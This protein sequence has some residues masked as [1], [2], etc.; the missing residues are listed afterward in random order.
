MRV[1]LQENTLIGEVKEA[2]SGG[3]I[4]KKRFVA[5]YVTWIA[6]LI[7][8][9]LGVILAV[10]SETKTVLDRCITIGF[11][12]IVAIV[13]LYATKKYLR[14]QSMVNDIQEV[15][16]R[17]N[18]DYVNG[19]NQLLWDRYKNKSQLFQS[20]ELNRIYRS[21]LEENYRLAESGETGT[22]ANIEDYFNYKLI[23]SLVKK[24]VMNLIAGAMTG[25]GILG[26]FIGLSVGLQHFSTGSTEEISNSIAPLMDG[27]KVA[28]HTSIYGMILS[29]LFNAAYKNDIEHAYDIMDDFL[30]SFKAK[31]AN[32][33]ETGMAKMMV[34]YQKKQSEEMSELVT[35]MAAQMSEILVPQFDRLNETLYNFADV[36]SKAQ[37]DGI[38]SIVESFVEQMNQSLGDRFKELAKV[39]DETCDWQR[40][41][42]A[43]MERVLNHVGAMTT[44]IER[45]N[46]LSEATIQRTSE[47]I[48]KVDSLQ[49]MIN[50]KMEA[51]DQRLAEYQTVGERQAD[52]IEALVNYEKSITEASKTFSADMVKQ[53]QILEDIESTI[54][55]NTVKN[56]ELLTS[57][58]EECSQAIAEAA[59]RQVESIVDI[60]NSASE[61]LNKA[62]EELGMVS[63]Q[64]GTELNASLKDAIDTVAHAS[65][66]CSTRITDAARDQIKSITD[67]T[68]S[69]SADMNTAA[70]GLNRAMAQMNDKMEQRIAK[71]FELFDNE[72]S[73]IVSHLSATISEVRETTGR[74][75]KVVFEAYEGMRT[76]ME[77]MEAN[78]K[79]MAETMERLRRKMDA[80]ITLF[81]ENE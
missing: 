32:N 53:V 77:E 68:Y 71:S 6:F 66:E 78:T 23:D 57:K 10:N 37:V 20:D 60:S 21:Y 24:N 80:M 31:V 69:A 79:K 17:I 11:F 70:E 49:D 54:S 12:V 73:E 47:Y 16:Q 39:L 56:M 3:I 58:A 27:I 74:V 41:T 7:V 5:I 34:Q 62:A 75:P 63:G 76:G 25:L 40:K 48:E 2:S 72:L 45:I 64:L 50:Q 35:D 36:A 67:M 81:D 46:E 29:L 61:S 43:D 14:L 28:F 30:D 42:S 18:V 9:G 44:N 51:F 22:F 1:L 13:F 8:V 65:E 15:T 4:M 19:G 55:D 33:P 52:Y 26:T 59:Q 38:K